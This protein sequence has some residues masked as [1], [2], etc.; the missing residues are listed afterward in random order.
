MSPQRQSRNQ[1][2]YLSAAE[3]KT[4]FQPHTNLE[5]V[6]IGDTTPVSLFGYVVRITG[7]GYCVPGI[8]AATG[9][10]KRERQS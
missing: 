9:P 2:A 7:V 5:I 6:K 4:F 8:H 1:A 3:I 10:K